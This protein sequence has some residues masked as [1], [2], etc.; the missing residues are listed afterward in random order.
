MQSLTTLR[1]AID[2]IPANGRSRRFPAPLK[3]AVARYVID[4]RRRGVRTAQLESDLSISWET[5]RRWTRD[6]RPPT[7]VAVHV[8]PDP[9]PAGVALVSPSGWRIEGLSLDDVRALVAS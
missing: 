8:T 5:L 2:E 9:A 4:A 3:A 1:S 6:A 7:P